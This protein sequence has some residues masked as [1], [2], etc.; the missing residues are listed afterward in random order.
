MQETAH[1]SIH[2]VVWNHRDALGRF[3]ASLERQTC[4][5]AQVIVLDNASSD[6]VQGW[7]QHSHP[8]VVALRNFRDH[9]VARAWNQSVALALSRE[10]D[11]MSLDQR[12][13]IFAEPDILFAPDALQKIVDTFTADPTLMIA[14]PCVQVGRVVADGDE[15]RFE[16]EPTEVMESTG[17][18]LTRGRRF[19]EKGKGTSEAFAVARGCFVVRAS[20]MKRLAVEGEWFDELVFPGQEVWD[21]CWRAHLLGMSVRMLPEATVYRL[22]ASSKRLTHEQRCA[23]FL[24]GPLCWKNDV[25][26]NRLLRLPW[27]VCDR[28]WT[29]LYL[30]THGRVCLAWLGTWRKRSAF[31]KKHAALFAQTHVSSAEMRRWFV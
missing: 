8:E 30:L 18:S 29:A 3:L 21:L 31:K 14:G 16:I 2:V 28:V 17:M 22:P 26:M 10:S 25:L 27:I 19:V 4:K 7:L 13:F 6:G 15:E 9:G 1:T 12:V 5:E 20:A 23:R 11:E 24:R